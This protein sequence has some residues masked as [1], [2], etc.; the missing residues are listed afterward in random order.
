MSTDKWNF[1][2]NFKLSIYI[3]MNRF[4]VERIEEDIVACNNFFTNFFHDFDVF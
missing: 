2:E 3:E 1:F 4:Q